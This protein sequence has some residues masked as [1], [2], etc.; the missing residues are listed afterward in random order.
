MMS[1]CPSR[2]HLLGEKVELMKILAS[3]MKEKAEL[4]EQKTMLMK[5]IMLQEEERL[6][7]YSTA[8]MEGITH[9]SIACVVDFHSS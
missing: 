3:L 4:Q 2:G 6:K 8:Q 5:K 9:T 7:T 1:I